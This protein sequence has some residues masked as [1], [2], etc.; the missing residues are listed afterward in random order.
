MLATERFREGFTVTVLTT[1][2][3][4]I[5]PPRFSLLPPPSM[6]SWKNWTYAGSA[7]LLIEIPASQGDCGVPSPV[8]VI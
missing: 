5:D 6:G 2:S 1:I 8:T 7:V 4:I 3:G